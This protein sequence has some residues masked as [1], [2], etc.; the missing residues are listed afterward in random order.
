MDAKDKFGKL[1]SGA[2]SVSV[3]NESK[4]KPDEDNESNIL[5]NIL[6]TSD[7]KGYIEKPNYYFNNVND[8]TRADLDLLMLTQGYRRFAWKQ[9][10]ADDFPK[11]VFQPE[12]SLEISGRMKNL[13]GRPVAH[14]KVT[15][16]SRTGGFLTLDTVT[17]DKGRFTFNNLVFSDSARFVI[18]GR[19]AKGGD[20]VE[21]ELDNIAPQLVTRNRNSADIEINISTN[22][23]A[24][25]KN[26]K[27]QYD[28]FL[29]YGLASQSHMLKDVA[30]TDKRI[31][32]KDS[33]NLNGGGNADQVIKLDQKYMCPTLEICLQGKL[34]GVRFINQIPYSSRTMYSSLGAGGD[35]AHLEPMQVVLDGMYVSPNFMS[36]I[37]PGDIE[38][39]EVLKSA[40]YTSIYGVKGFAGLIILTTKRGGDNNYKRYTPDIITYKPTGVY[41]AREFYSPRYD[42]PKTNAKVADLRSTIYWNPNVITD[43][44]GLACVEFF[45]ADSPGIYR[46]VIEGMDAD[47]NIGRQVFRYKV[48]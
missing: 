36:H 47:G 22:I 34:T 1:I 11:Q 7:I 21:V 17:D 16:F 5:A 24:Y 4:I 27:A 40:M 32:Y 33:Q 43:E 25:L 23:L 15:L 42:D 19:N 35:N 37:S 46:A 13:L 10:M 44:N 20:K 41:A 31:I 12:K 29:K 45:N 2:F 9:I 8:K 18:Q 3:T 14:G 6:L 38:T 48:E 26:S 39:V 30:I 28:D